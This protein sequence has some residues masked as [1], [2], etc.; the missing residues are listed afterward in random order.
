MEAEHYRLSFIEG[1]DG[2][3]A[4]LAFASNT[5]KIYRKAV[6]SGRKQGYAKP[7]HA[8]LPEYK[9]SFIKSYLILKAYLAK[10]E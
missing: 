10:G 7:H 6:L 2:K 9:R 3:E 4:A 8:S 1:R 5:L